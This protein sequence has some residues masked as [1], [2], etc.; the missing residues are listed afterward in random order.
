MCFVLQLNPFTSINICKYT[1]VC[2]VDISITPSLSLL[3]SLSL[4]LSLSL[5]LN[6][7]LGD[8]DANTSLA[9][10]QLVSVM[11]EKSFVLGL[12]HDFI[13]RLRNAGLDQ[14][15]DAL[16]DDSALTEEHRQTLDEICAA[17]GSHSEALDGHAPEQGTVPESQVTE[18]E[19]EGDRERKS[20]AEKGMDEVLR[21]QASVKWAVGALAKRSAQGHGGAVLATSLKAVQDMCVLSGEGP[22]TEEEMLFAL[23]RQLERY[24]FQV[25]L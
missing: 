4:S 6:T 16:L 8:V 25:G 9:A 1:L 20:G 17:L 3:L 22:P 7:L 21:A 13:A 11:L 15:L 14:R 23:K 5:F 19:E 18:V 12:S 10:A 2:P 24:A